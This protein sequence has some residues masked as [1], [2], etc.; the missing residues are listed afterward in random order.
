MSVR[1][2]MRMQ[3]GVDTQVGPLEIAGVDATDRLAICSARL[4]ERTP[5]TEHDQPAGL[6]ASLRAYQVR[7]VTRGSTS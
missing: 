7:R 1:E 6:D 5:F 2:A 4:Q 3:I